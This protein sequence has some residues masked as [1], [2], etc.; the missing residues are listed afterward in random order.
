MRSRIA[1]FGAAV[2]L[3]LSVI[4]VLS[5]PAQA[6]TTP[7]VSGIDTSTPGHLKFTVTTDAPYAFV[8]WSENSVSKPTIGGE[9]AFDLTVWGFSAVNLLVRGCPSDLQNCTG[10]QAANVWIPEQ[11][12]TSVTWDSDRLIG[13]AELFSVTVTDTLGGHLYVQSQ[14]PAPDGTFVEVAKSGTTQ[15]YLGTDGT[16]EVSLIRCSD[17]LRIHCRPSSSA[18]LVTINQVL[19]SYPL[20]RDLTASPDNTTAADTEIRI[21]HSEDAL[22]GINEATVEW[23]LYSGGASASGT[24]TIPFTQGVARLPLDL[25]GLPDG[26]YEFHARLRVVSART[27]NITG[28]VSGVTVTVDTKA[29]TAA[30]LK[31]PQEGTLFPYPDGYRDVGWTLTSSEQGAAH[32]EVIDSTGRILRT[33]NSTVDGFGNAKLSWD[34]KDSLGNWVTGS[35]HFRVT[36]EDLVH[37]TGIVDERTQQV[38]PHEFAKLSRDIV[39][40]AKKTE[41]RWHGKCS[42]FKSPSSHR[43]PGSLA[44]NSSTKCKKKSWKKSGLIAL[45][46]AELPPAVSYLRV[47]IWMSG[48]N[49]LQK[50]GSRAFAEVWNAHTGAFHDEPT[51]L[52]SRRSTH[53][54][55]FPRN[56]LE[57]L[58][59]GRYVAW[60]A[61]TWAPARYDLLASKVRVNYKI[62]VHPVTGATWIP[63]EFARAGRMGTPP[64]MQQSAAPPRGLRFG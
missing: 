23:N 29:P 39:V 2:A 44:L 15:V 53:S 51:T 18:V 60:R 56:S 41:W 34:G 48:A 9:A 3:A 50:R 35:V 42:S 33:V 12:V 10:L 54:L 24:Q 6:F 57:V 59:N 16:R 52:Y 36:L 11:A 25:T 64:R 30:F 58:Y 7:V 40:R 22:D 31:G 13:E 63:P 17:T 47:Q 49:S 45:Y 46:E 32:L 20:D 55:Y 37:N 62:F 27:G 38:Y 1:A 8:F 19:S 14:V 43:W 5:A 61:L 26:Q 28:Y 21:S 4:P